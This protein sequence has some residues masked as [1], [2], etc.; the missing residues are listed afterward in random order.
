MH[1]AL[2]QQGQDCCPDVAPAA[3]TVPAPTPAPVPPA[4]SSC[5]VATSLAWPIASH[6]FSQIG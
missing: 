5:V 4:P 1:R 3:T 6:R 2:G